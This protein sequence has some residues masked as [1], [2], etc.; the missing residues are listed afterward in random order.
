MGR[1]FYIFYKKES[2]NIIG[3]YKFTNKINNKSYIG[4]SVNIEDRK[5][6][7]KYYSQ[8]SN[9]AF[10]KAVNQYGWDN[11]EFSVLEEC[12]VKQLDEREKYWI[13]FYDSYYNDYNMTKGGQYGNSSVGEQNGRTK[14]KDSDVLEIRNKVYLENK[15]IWEVYE[16]YKDKVGKDRFWSLVHGDTWKN[17][18]CSMIYSLKDRSYQAFTGSKNPKAKLTKDQVKE[19]RFKVEQENQNPE[20]LYLS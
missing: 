14:L 20:D 9:T 15:D 16:N 18:D 4:Q 1:I 6:K 5:I 11:F 8:H 17:V 19:I 13:E 3:I 12:S 7:H 10:Y 2:V